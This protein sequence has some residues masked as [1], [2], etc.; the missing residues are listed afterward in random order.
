MS[1]SV[2]ELEFEFEITAEALRAAH[3]ALGGDSGG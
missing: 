2:P 3:G 1:G